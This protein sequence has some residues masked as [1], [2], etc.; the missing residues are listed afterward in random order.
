MRMEEGSAPP[1]SSQPLS[2]QPTANRPLAGDCCGIWRGGPQRFGA[3]R[4]TELVVTAA[5]PRSLGHGRGRSCLCLSR[6]VGGATLAH[7]DLGVSRG[8]QR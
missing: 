1:A 6:F 5:S 4:S 3:K 2:I 7:E 8:R